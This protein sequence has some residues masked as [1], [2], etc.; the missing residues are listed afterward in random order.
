[1]AGTLQHVLHVGLEGFSQCA[2]DELVHVGDR[3]VPR[4]CNVIAGQCA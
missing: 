2:G 3:A 1:M 4:Y